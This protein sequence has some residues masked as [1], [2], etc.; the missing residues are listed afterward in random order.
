MAEMIDLYNRQRHPLNQTAERGAPLSAGCYRVVVTGWI[1]S[2]KGAF[3]MVRRKAGPAANDG[4]WEAPGGGVQAGETS[5]AAVLRE[6]KEELGIEPDIK[7]VKLFSSERQDSAHAFYDVFLLRADTKLDELT[8]NADELAE[9]RWM[10]PADIDELSR[11]GLLSPYMRY[12][13][14][15]VYPN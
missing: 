4:L 6:V 1:E 3:L 11:A 15:V 7:T 8:V 5:L 2:A 13:E 10:M 14:D 9:A 12:Y